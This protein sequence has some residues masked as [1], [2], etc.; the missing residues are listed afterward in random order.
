L[1]QQRALAAVSQKD[2]SCVRPKNYPLL[3]Y[4]TLMTTVSRLSPMTG[5]RGLSSRFPA[6]GK[7]R[8]SQ[9]RSCFLSYVL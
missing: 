2:T 3:Y 5:T 4:C 9:L 8:A 1:I 7:S 6:Y